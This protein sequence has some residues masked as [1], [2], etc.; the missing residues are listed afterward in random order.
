[1]ILLGSVCWLM[2]ELQKASVPCWTLK[3]E[4]ADTIS[5]VK[6]MPDDALLNIDDPLV[7]ILL[8]IEFRFTPIGGMPG[9]G[10]RIDISKS[11]DPFLESGGP[12]MDP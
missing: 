5:S 7:I 11:G 12:N 8:F 4:K 2:K 1:M 3:E 10:T 6:S 9:L